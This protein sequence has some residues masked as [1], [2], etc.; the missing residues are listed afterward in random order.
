MDYAFAGIYKRV[1]DT[2]RRTPYGAN[3]NVFD[4]LIHRQ[5]YSWVIPKPIRNEP[6]TLIA[7]V[8]GRKRPPK[9]F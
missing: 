9:R 3:G 8:A 6:V 5:P 1:A 7:R 2:M 4:N